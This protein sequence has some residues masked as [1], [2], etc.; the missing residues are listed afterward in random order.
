[1][2]TSELIDKLNIE[3]GYTI[4]C[5]LL[6]PSLKHGKH[7]R[8]FD[9]SKTSQDVFYLKGRKLNFPHV[10]NY[11]SGEHWTP[12]NA[13]AKAHDLSFGETLKELKSIYLLHST[14]EKK[15]YI[16]PKIA[17]QIQEYPPLEVNVSEY[18]SSI[19]QRHQSNLI[20][21]LRK[22]YGDALVKK[23]LELYEV[24]FGEKV[25][26]TAFWYKDKD[27]KVINAKYMA[28]NKTLG[29]RIKDINANWYHSSK[30]KSMPKMGLYGEHLMAPTIWVVES[31]K[32][33]LICSI[34]FIMNDIN[35]M[36]VWACGG[37]NRLISSFQNCSQDLSNKRI[38]LIPDTDAKDMN[39][40]QKA[41]SLW[42]NKINELYSMGIKVEISD[43]LE[44]KASYAQKINKIDIADYFLSEYIQNTKISLPEEVYK[45]Y[46]YEEKSIDLNKL[47][48]WTHYFNWY[49]DTKHQ[50]LSEFY[51][52]ILVC[53]SEERAKEQIVRN[54]NY[55]SDDKLNIWLSWIECPENIPHPKKLISTNTQIPS[56]YDKEK[57]SNY[58]EAITRVQL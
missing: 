44:K 5:D 11:S 28:Y 2:E 13:Y 31:E 58:L 24:G 45:Q 27:G 1:M 41:F 18:S 10:H 52:Y 7:T 36:I 49:K 14:E 40:P 29:K 48:Y 37:L 35:N 53:G 3:Y 8:L 30:R 51:E 42:S 16:P 17:P 43:F 47:E 50:E 20:S 39:D 4:F 57:F 15:K 38:I 22:I 12:I 55:Q 25:Y 6:G 56:W 46:L 34:H 32:T 9:T 26:D 21:F 54:L 19:S 33:A 23:V